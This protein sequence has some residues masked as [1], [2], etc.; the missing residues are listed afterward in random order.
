HTSGLQDYLELG[1]HTPLEQA[2]K[3]HILPHLPQW[4]SIAQ[5][6]KQFEYCNTNYFVLALAIE[7]VVGDSFNRL[8]ESQL[9]VPAGLSSTSLGP[10]ANLAAAKG[11]ARAGYGIPTFE[12]A[13]NFLLDTYGD[14][15]IFSCLS[16]LMNW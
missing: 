12:S 6:G 16:D 13:E 14:G 1:I 3:L 8:L 2:S 9:F 15:G 7:R 11:Y 4:M 5:A 10:S